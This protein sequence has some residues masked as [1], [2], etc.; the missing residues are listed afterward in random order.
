MS[1]PII[2]PKGARAAMAKLD[3]QCQMLQ[4]KDQTNAD[5]Q[6]TIADLMPEAEELRSKVDNIGKLRVADQRLHEQEIEKV[7][8]D[9]RDYKDNWEDECEARA[10]ESEEFR[11]ER[12]RFT[13]EY[14]ELKTHNATLAQKCDGLEAWVS[15]LL[16]F[17]NAKDFGQLKTEL[18]HLNIKVDQT[19]I[20]LDHVSKTVQQ[21]SEETCETV[22]ASLTAVAKSV[23]ASVQDTTNASNRNFSKLTQALDEMTIEQSKA[24]IKANDEDRVLA[25]FGRTTVKRAAKP[26]ADTT[27]Q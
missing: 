6:R 25:R 1:T 9:L 2:D 12:E 17:V 22:N 5:L 16:S 8:E 18:D 14:N 24:R 19:N 3:L 10:Q 13:N 4:E 11:Q 7:R 21:A 15:D 20:K 27:S 26:P 23:H